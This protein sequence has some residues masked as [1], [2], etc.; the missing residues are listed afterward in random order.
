M[1]LSHESISRIENRKL[2]DPLY[3]QNEEKKRNEIDLFKNLVCI[4][5]ERE[6]EKRV[7]ERD[8]IQRKG[9]RQGDERNLFARNQ[10]RA[11]RRKNDGSYEDTSS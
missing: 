8:V 4:M 2:F 6:K 11:S 7:K 1:F 10:A 9:E 5:K 3:T